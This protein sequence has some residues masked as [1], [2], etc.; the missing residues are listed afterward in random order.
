MKAK[1]RTT[2]IKRAAKR[3]PKDLTPKMR[4]SGGSVAT[5]I[6]T[7]KHEALKTIANNLRA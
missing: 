1:K 5:N 6:A 7:M 4:V 2:K 3:A